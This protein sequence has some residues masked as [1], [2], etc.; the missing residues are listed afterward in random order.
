LTNFTNPQETSLQQPPI[1][2]FKPADRSL[3]VPGARVSLA[4]QV[5]DGKPTATRVNAGSN[6]FALPY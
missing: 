2:T 6:G 3:L 5:L 1:V 4:A